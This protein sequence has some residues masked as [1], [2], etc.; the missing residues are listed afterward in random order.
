MFISH[1]YFQSEKQSEIHLLPHDLLQYAASGSRGRLYSQIG[2]ECSGDV[3]G[4]DATMN[5]LW[6]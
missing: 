6:S 4:D 1:N 5:F 2:R 3:Y